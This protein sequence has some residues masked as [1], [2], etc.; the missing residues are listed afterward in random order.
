MK[1]E[2]GNRAAALWRRV[3]HLGRASAFDRELDDEMSLH[4]ELRAD[5]LQQDGMTR[6]DALARA[7]REFGSTLRV[8]EETRAAWQ[9]QWLEETRSDL[10]YAWRAL[11]RN[12]GLA[13]AAVF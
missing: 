11:R 9:Y 4:I 1:I 5:E 8:R 12:P 10:S 13:A 3:S 6:E 7:L 2:L